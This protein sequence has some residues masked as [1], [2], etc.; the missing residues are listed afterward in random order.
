M[1]KKVIALLLIYSILM[2]GGTKLGIYAY[3]QLNKDYISSVLCINKDKPVLQCNGKCFLSKKLKAEEEKEK[4]APVEVK[5][6]ADVLYFSEYSC[7]SVSRD[8]ESISTVKSSYILGT[9]SVNRPS[10]FHP[11]LA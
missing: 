7:V 2:Q 8:F 10:V 6:I 4:K 9:Y 5:S 11:P 1:L 3:F